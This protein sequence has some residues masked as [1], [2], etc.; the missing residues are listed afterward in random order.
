MRL[1]TFLAPALLLASASMLA[2]SCGPKERIRLSS[3]PPA[4]FS[5]EA[6]PKLDPQVVIQNDEEGF[7]GHQRDKDEWGQRGW[8]ALDRVCHWFQDQGVTGL[9]CTLEPA[10]P[11]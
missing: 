11:D 7:R 2:T 10:K 1:H 6:R 8:A 5:Q 3:P 9:P 4:A